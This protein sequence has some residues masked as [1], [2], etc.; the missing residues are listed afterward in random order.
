MNHDAE[1]ITVFCSRLDA[2]EDVQPL[3]T[4]EWNELAGMLRQQELRPGYLLDFERKDFIEQLGFPEEKADRFMR[5]IDRSGSLQFALSEYANRGIY[6][7]TRADEAYPSQLKH[8]LKPAQVPPLFYYA[9][10]LSLLEK[11]AVGYVGSRDVAEEDVIFTQRTVAKTVGNG[12]AVVSGGAKGADTF[13]ERTA[14]NEDGFAVE[15]L[16]DS[17]L[18]KLR[19]SDLLRAIRD[20]RILILSAVIPTAGFSVGTAMMRNKYIYAQSSGTVVIRTDLNKGGTWHG[21]VENLRNKWCR[22]FCRNCSYPGNRELIR[23]GAV[24]I[25]D[26]W[27][28]DEAALLPDQEEEQKDPPKEPEQISIFELLSGPQ[29]QMT[30][31][32][33]D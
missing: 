2:A 23:L 11:K 7:I 20:G 31:S 28:G 24:A 8:K 14:L 15:F 18:R 5:L 9:G 33:G 25:G 16:S 22:T 12:F 29:E 6:I 17:M 26:D 21:A 27:A 32:Q 3:E 19:D 10:D 1:A 4:Q 30:D 13:S